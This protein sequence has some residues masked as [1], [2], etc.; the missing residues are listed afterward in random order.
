MVA[1]IIPLDS[2]ALINEN[3]LLPVED[4]LTTVTA[5]SDESFFQLDSHNF[6][7]FFKNE[8]IPL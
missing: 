3:N 8:S 2:D 5:V 7:H 4:A 6:P 1:P